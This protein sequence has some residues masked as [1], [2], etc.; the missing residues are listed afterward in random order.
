MSQAEHP[1]RRITIRLHGRTVQRAAE[2]SQNS[3]LA[4]GGDLEKDASRWDVADLRIRASKWA[5]AAA[6]SLTRDS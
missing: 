6:Q 4:K 3:E 5:L 2:R 1:L